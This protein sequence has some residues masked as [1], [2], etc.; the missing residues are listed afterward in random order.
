MR[1]FFQKIKT[2]KKL[3]AAAVCIL[4]AVIVLCVCLSAYMVSTYVAQNK[5]DTVIFEYDFNEG[6]GEF[7]ETAWNDE[8]TVFKH[9]TSGGI[10]DSGCVMVSNVWENDARYELKLAV[11]PKSYYRISGWIKTENIY[12]NEG[13][14]GANISVLE[15]FEVY[16]YLYG[17]NDW[18]YVEFYGKTDKSQEEII[19]A[20]RVGFYSGDNT[21]IAW[22]DNINV[23]QVGE[24]P[25]GV[26]AL[27]LKPIL[28]EEASEE[29]E[30]VLDENF[31]FDTTKALGIL[32]LFVFLAFVIAYRF[33]RAYDGFGRKERLA[34]PF[35]NA[36]SLT[37]GLLVIF[38]AGILIRVIFALSGIQCS[39]DVNLFKYWGNK[40]VEGGLTETYNTLG[41]NIDYPPLYVYAL[42][43]ASLIKNA[44]SF[45]GDGTNIFYSLLIKLT[46]ILADCAIGVVIYLMLDK[47][48]RTEWK[49]LAVA[50]W[51]LNPISIINS[52]CWG[53]VDSVLALI[54]LLAVYFAENNKP[55]LSGLMLGLGMMLKPQAIIIFPLVFYILFRNFVQSKD[56]ISKRFI[57]AL[58]TLAGFVIGAVLPCI[59][60]MFKMGFVPVELFGKT[61]SVPWIV[62]LFIGTANHYAYVCVNALNLW[63]ILG[64]NW[65]PDKELFGPA[66]LFTLGILAIVIVCVLV[67]VLYQVNKKAPFMTYMLAAALYMG[68][69]MFST[70]MHERYFFPAVVF[71]AVALVLSNNKIVLWLYSA[72]SIFGFL[73][74]AEVLLDL[75]VG[76]ALKNAGADM[77]VYGNYL[78]VYETDYRMFIAYAMVIITLLLF[79][80]A[81]WYAVS[82]GDLSK[83][84]FGI[85]KLENKEDKEIEHESGTLFEMV[86]DA[87][88]DGECDADNEIY[89]CDVKEGDGGNE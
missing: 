14:A 76:Q 79:M 2:D 78:W 88:T 38:A 87:D 24:L 41:D 74:I 73:T 15:N 81:I 54:V 60:F 51:M 5:E 18:T 61:V 53:Q 22:F 13:F 37:K 36:L 8:N 70:R 31:Y 66:S 57:P 40:S 64:K 67:W 20:L 16:E 83:N 50:A 28:G 29:E 47:R 6:V 3:F 25:D 11:E 77:A 72:L 49:L 69:A 17:T 63:F 75:E 32:T 58:L 45:L 23:T 1:K 82:P 27:N 86:F 48:M 46:P 19:I 33:A 56:K 26:E 55:L 44:F 30:N 21:G 89:V 84:W 12:K 4:A 34:P 68:V 65:V 59:P 62:S 9:C 35:G 52:S 85:W 43:F 7:T 39:V 10:D 71:L 42:Y 80:F